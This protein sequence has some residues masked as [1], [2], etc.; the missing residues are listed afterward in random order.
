M[1]VLKK[2]RTGTKQLPVFLCCQIGILRVYSFFKT[3]RK[4]SS[5]ETL[6]LYV[7]RTVKCLAILPFCGGERILLKLQVDMDMCDCHKS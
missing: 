4:M 5:N 7:M 1:L 6:P 2:G 3:V